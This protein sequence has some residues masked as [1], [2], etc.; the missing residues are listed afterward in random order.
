MQTLE[1]FVSE[2]VTVSDIFGTIM[3]AIKRW[4]RN[5]IVFEEADEE[6]EP[7]DADDSPESGTDPPPLSIQV[8]DVA[9]TKD[10]F[11]G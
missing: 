4:A 11:G 1:I 10:I 8:K 2:I 7:H 5:F 3:V 6:D 9:N